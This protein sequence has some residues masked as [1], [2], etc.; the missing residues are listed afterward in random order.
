MRKTKELNNLHE[1]TLPKPIKKGGSVIYR[2]LGTKFDKE[3]G[4]W[5]GPLSQNIPSRFTVYDEEKGENVD[6]AYLRRVNGDGSYQLGEIEFFKHDGFQKTLRNRPEDIEQYQIL[7]LHPLNAANSAEYGVRPVFERVDEGKKAKALREERIAK[8]QA[9]DIALEMSDEQIQAMA[10]SMGINPKLDLEVLRD[11]IEKYAEEKPLEF[12]TRGV[13]LTEEIELAVREA[14]ELRVVTF[15]KEDNSWYW[16]ANDEKIY[17]VPRGPKPGKFK[18]FATFLAA[19]EAI[20]KEVK[21]QVQL[22]KR[23]K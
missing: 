2:L 4:R 18:G 12:V 15:K 11:K 19:E 22:A 7:E 5:I 14:E 13:D 16:V 8:K 6:C 21:E 3:T 17:A 20:C 1:K 23:V 9:M 10:I